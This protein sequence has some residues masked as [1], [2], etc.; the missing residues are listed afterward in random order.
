MLIGAM[1]YPMRDLVEEIHAFAEAGFDFVD[2]TLEPARARAGELDVKAARKALD[3]TGL[4]AVG[5]TA[6]YLPIASQ[7]PELRQAAINELERCLET[8]SELN[9][10]LMNVHPDIHLAMRDQ[11]TLAREN[12]ESI[13]LLTGR[14]QQLGVRLMVENMAGFFSDPPF[15]RP[16]FEAAPAAG[17]HLD[18]GH[19]T[20]YSERNR[21][22]ELLAAFADRLTHVH[23]SDNKGGDQDLHLPLGAGTINWHHVIQALKR[24][25]YNATIT[26]E[27]FSRER[28][29]LKLSRRLL[30]Q[31][32][33]EAQAG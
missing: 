11:M 7:F 18:V 20:L 22:D 26:I 19:S 6:W 14:G 8:F 4:Q 32:W 2:I 15:L 24:A 25:G 13:A 27:D 23:V 33:D 31:W 30:R 21:I 3:Q 5:H 9:V 12:A 28:E 10:H 16:I 1:N 17:F 29:L